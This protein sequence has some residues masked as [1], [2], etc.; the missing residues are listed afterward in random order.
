MDKRYK[1]YPNVPTAAELGYPDAVL[2]TYV[3]LYI[4]KN[5]QENIKKTLLDVCKKIYDDPEFKKGIEGLGEE[6]KW[7]GPEFIK[8]GIKKQEEIGIPILKELGMVVGK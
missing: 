2:P 5:T 6:P 3:G 8:E 7:G 1:D 4:H